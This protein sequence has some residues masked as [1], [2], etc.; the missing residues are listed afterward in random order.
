MASNTMG[1]T[2]YRDTERE[3][4]QVRADEGRR[5]NRGREVTDRQVDT[6]VVGQSANM[7][8]PAGMY[9]AAPATEFIEARD[10]TR[11]GPIWAGMLTTFT[12]FLILEFLGVGLGLISPTNGNSGATSGIASAIAGLIAFFLG[13]WIAESTAVARGAGAG[14]LNGF[15]VWALAITLILILSILGLGTL[16]G[17]LGN[18]AGQFLAAGHTVTTPSVGGVSSS[19]VS[20]VTQAAG[21]GGFISMVI[22]ALAAALGGLLASRGRAFG[23]VRP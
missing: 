13:G 2:E 4:E 12:S 21:W 11:W 6:S 10:R 20:G 7:A 1:P 22:S 8:V 5:V 3:R 15:L 9:Q 14:L 16:F 19:Q 17:A 18:V 23:W